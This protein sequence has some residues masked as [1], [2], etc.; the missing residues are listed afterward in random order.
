MGAKKAWGRHGGA[1][2][3]R[4]RQSGASHRGTNKALGQHWLT[5]RL[6]LAEIAD[7][8]AGFIPV[9][10]AYAW[11]ANDDLAAFS[12]AKLAERPLNAPLRPLCIEIG[13]GQGALT[14]R[15][16]RRFKRVVAVEF[17]A[18]LAQNLPKSFPGTP[19]E[20]V[21]GDIL[22]VD[23]AELVKKYGASGADY[24]IVGNIPY[25]I[26]SPIIEKVL[27]VVPRPQRVVLL[28]QKEVAERV[29]SEK[30][31]VLSLWVKNRAKVSLGPVVGRTN[32]TPPPKVDS[33]VL[34]M[35]PHASEVSEAVFRVIRQGFKAPRKKLV[36][37]LAGA[38]PVLT[39]LGLSLDARPGDLGLED[40]QRLA[41]KLQSISKNLPKS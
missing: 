24:V 31:T 21:T 18:R 16:L 1:N 23:I 8:A 6:I 19:L 33:Q 35:E 22:T 11:N 2:R 39:E 4:T 37:N 7:L 5:N 14:G 40:W 36:H 9:I 26:T 15:L 38:R 20:V 10:D 32:F 25:Y 27:T 34:V 17:D 30:E 13:P 41:K 29:A 12:G 28:V 3:G